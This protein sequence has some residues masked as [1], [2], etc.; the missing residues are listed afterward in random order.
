[1]FVIVF[2]KPDNGVP[3]S[4]CSDGDN[5]L[6]RNG[7]PSVF[8]GRVEVCINN[9][10]GTVCGKQ[11]DRLDAEVVC[12]NQGFQADHFVRTDFGPGTGP[13]FLSSLNCN[14][15]ETSLLDCEAFASTGVHSCDHSM[16]IGV[17]C[18]CK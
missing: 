5:R 10:W 16:D 17:Y 8:E 2:F 11:F 4:N 15:M 12:R 1:M 18:E 13:I 7:Q 6:I 3:Y 14:G 9:A